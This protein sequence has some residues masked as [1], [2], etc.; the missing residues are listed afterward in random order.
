M[1]PWIA[2]FGIWRMNDMQNTEWLAFEWNAKKDETGESF[3]TVSKN[4]CDL[5]AHGGDR[6]YA[7]TE[8]KVPGP[9]Y[10]MNH[11]KFDYDN[12]CFN[13]MNNL[14]YNEVHLKWDDPSLIPQ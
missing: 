7:Y 2:P 13:C 1:A 8:C 10:R 5:V 12:D 3:E 11:S 9:T 6:R 4:R 14:D